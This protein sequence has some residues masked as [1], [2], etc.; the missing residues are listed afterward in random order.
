[1]I[2]ALATILLAAQDDL[3]PGLIGEYFKFDEGIEDFPDVKNKKPNIRRADK[4]LNWEGTGE[5]FAGT[6]FAEDFYVRWTGVVRIPKD[7]K[8]T[9]FTESDDGSR[10][11]IDGKQVVDNGGLHAMEEKEGTAELKA[12]PH[13]IKIDFFENEGG[14][15]C[16]A[17]WEAEGVAKEVVPEKVLFHKKGT[18]K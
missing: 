11:F 15:G 1:M 7:G 13:D 6:G 10:L 14:A 9:F 2:N 3:K 4:E 16:I 5:E 12:G 17:R 18:E 8:Y